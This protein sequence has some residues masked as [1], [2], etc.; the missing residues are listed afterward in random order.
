MRAI[1]SLHDERAGLA[2]LRAGELDLVILERR[3]EAPPLRGVATEDLLRD[4]YR[5][6]VPKGWPAAGDAETLLRGPWIAGHEGTPAR[7]ALEALASTT[8]LRPD[9]RHLCHE[10]TSM[11]ALVGAGL[12]AAVV[13]DLVLDF[14]PLTNVRV[15]TGPLDPGAR[16]IYVAHRRGRAEPGPAAA[17]TL[18]ALRTHAT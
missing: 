2:Q 11:L 16:T 10:Y 12:G 9:I 14:L 4:A 18:E 17:A 6:V 13:T 15:T 5:V 8:R 7:A 3:P 1:L